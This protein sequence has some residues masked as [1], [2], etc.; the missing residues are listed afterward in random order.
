MNNTEKTMEK[1]LRF[2]KAEASFSREAIFTAVL[3]I[4]GTTVRWVQDLKIMLRI[5]GESVSFRKEE[6]AMRWTQTFLCT[7]EYGKQAVM[8]SLSRTFIRLQGMQNAP[9]S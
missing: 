3:Q 1:L 2:A 4:L 8:F 6:T 5:P 9:Q 7:Q